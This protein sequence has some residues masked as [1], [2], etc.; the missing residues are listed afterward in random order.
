MMDFLKSFFANEK[1]PD[2]QVLAAAQKKRD[3]LIVEGYEEPSNEPQGC[4]S[5]DGAAQTGGCGGCGC[6]G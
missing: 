2:E 4:G 5:S 1:T 6:R 3:V